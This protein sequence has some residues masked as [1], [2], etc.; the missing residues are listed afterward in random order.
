MADIKLSRNEK[1]LLRQANRLRTNMIKRAQ[2]DKNVKKALE[3]STEDIKIFSRGKSKKF[4]ITSEMTE[5]QKRA[6][7]RSAESLTESVYAREK[8]TQALYRRQ[9]KSFAENYN[10]SYRQAGQLINLFDKDENPEVAD[11]WEKIK[12]TTT[13]NAI[14]PLLKSD[15]KLAD[16][17]NNIGDKKFGLMMRLYTESGLAKEMNFASFLSDKEIVGFFNN[18]NL[19][20]LEDFVNDKQW[21]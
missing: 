9:R 6:M 19:D 13:Y 4:E 11:A 14:V 1:E 17:V 5:R 18:N 12:S 21:R 16:V 8:S 7:L 3:F 15:N 2:H 10:L 20:T